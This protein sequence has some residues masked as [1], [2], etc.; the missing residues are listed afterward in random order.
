MKI[1]NVPNIPGLVFLLVIIRLL[2]FLSQYI[3]TYGV[4]MTLLVELSIF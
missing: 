3:V 4:R 2:V 1:V